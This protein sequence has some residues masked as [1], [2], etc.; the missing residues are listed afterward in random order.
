MF[1]GWAILS[2]LSKWSGWAPGDVGDM[3]NGARGW[4]LWIS[5]GIMCADSLVSLLPVAWEYLLDAWKPFKRGYTS[6]GEHGEQDKRKETETADRLVP[7]SWVAIG[8]VLSI[9]IGT[10]LVWIVFGNEG[11]KPWATLLGFILG[12]MLSII[13]YVNSLNQIFPPLSSN[14]SIVL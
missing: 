14:L 13:G 11:I 12:G 7:N 6:I 1:V 9:A 8:L 5:L 2:P 4:I 3:S 10:L